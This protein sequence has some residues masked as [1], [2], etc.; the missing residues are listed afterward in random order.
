M[1]LSYALFFFFIFSGK[2]FADSEIDSLKN[3][4]K[5]SMDTN[6]V[7]ILNQLCWKLRYSDFKTSLAYGKEAI[8]LSE[9]IG[10]ELGICQAY[11]FTGVVYRN[12]G[13][14]LNAGKNF[15][16]ALQIAEKANIKTEVGY[17]YNNI[18]DVL[19]SQGQNQEALKFM[20]KAVAV[21]KEINDPKGLAYAY[22]RLGEMYQNIGENQKALDFFYKCLQVRQENKLTGVQSALSQIGKTYDK[23][24]DYPKALQYLEKA[25][26]MTQK[27]KD[28]QGEYQVL[29]DISS[30]FMAS[31]RQSEALSYTLRS[32]EI[33]EKMGAK[34]GIKRCCESLSTIY[35]QKKDYEKAFFYQTKYI[36]LQEQ[37]VNEEN[38][39]YMASIHHNYELEK[40]QDEIR[41][42]NKDRRIRELFTDIMI[43][44]IV[45]MV[46]IT[47]II[48]RVSLQRKQ[49]NKVLQEKNQ[50]IE[51]QSQ[52]LQTAH[53]Q[54]SHQ[55]QELEQTL[56][57]VT[58]V[59]SQ[60]V[61]SEK[62]A[63]LGQLVAGVAHEINNPINFVSAG[64]ETLESILEE[65]M[66]VIKKYEVY[67]QILPENL[68]EWQ[69]KI[70][71]IRKKADFEGLQADTF[72]LL[73]DIKNGAVRTAEIVKGL[74]TFSRL[75]E[76][77]IKTA[78][79][80]ENIDSTLIILKDRIELIKEYDPNLPL[81][82]CYP[83]QLNQVFMNILSNAIQATEKGEVKIR[84]WQEAQNVFVSFSDT[85]SGMSQ[86][87]Q[88]RIF[89]PFFTTKDVGK[90][91]GLGL[92]I[93]HS[94]IEKHQ[95]SIKV[96]S[97]IGFGTTFTICL[98]I[99]RSE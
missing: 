29:E 7:K 81:I 48:L 62:M 37:L 24:K 65:L 45:S 92:S 23:L 5:S 55:N 60:L 19:K 36:K 15:Y 17:S 13:D 16:K 82:D 59:Q 12:Q 89:E 8:A 79:L 84:T 99:Q 41:L 21:F 4:L 83:G 57:Q 35:S 54:L 72:L 38:A 91:T 51:Q 25:L 1:R 53:E 69:E 71:K 66:E 61:Q 20:Q 34:A 10:Y 28:L 90:G 64:T 98:P 85:G 56:E 49:L 18:G 42:L 86:E 97:Q 31:N 39:K 70:K 30:V 11:S 95:G 33:A 44:V 27:D 75:D 93:S 63:S 3:L 40:K 52:H 22:I 6:R 78:N 46:V 26:E 68:A 76:N 50:E 94:I 9:E 32:L 80:H 67:D 14:Y 77:D 47:I 74:R 87:V 58:T 96:A 2:S 88:D 73:S 43:G